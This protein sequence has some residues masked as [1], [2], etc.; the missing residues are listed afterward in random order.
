[1]F[2]NTLLLLEEFLCFLFSDK[3]TFLFLLWLPG[4]SKAKASF[5]SFQ[6]LSLAI[7]QLRIGVNK[8]GLMGKTVLGVLVGF[9]VQPCHYVFVEK[10][11]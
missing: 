10:K 7:Q 11:L 1:M 3:A 9:E 6:L 5:S 8:G 4:H 2:L